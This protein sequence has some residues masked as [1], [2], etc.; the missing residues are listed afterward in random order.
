M[1]YKSQKEL[2]DIGRAKYGRRDNNIAN[3]QNV[4]NSVINYIRAGKGWDSETTS[5]DQDSIIMTLIPAKNPKQQ[6]KPIVDMI[7][8]LKTKLRIPTGITLDVKEL[9][10]KINITITG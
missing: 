4:V 7:T 9:N 5:G 1:D 3:R 6:T 2:A 10:G 8:E